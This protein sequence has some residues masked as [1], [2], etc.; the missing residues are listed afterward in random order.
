MNK[1]LLRVVGLVCASPLYIHPPSYSKEILHSPPISCTLLLLFQQHIHP[2]GSPPHPPPNL[3][4][5]S[6]PKTLL[7]PLNRIPTIP[8]P[9]KRPLTLLAPILL[10]PQP[11]PAQKLA[12]TG[13]RGFLLRGLERDELVEVFVD[14]GGFAVAAGGLVGGT[15]AGVVLAFCIVVGE[16]EMARKCIRTD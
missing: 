7:I 5:P 14:G 11:L 1:S 8:I 6:D 16:G 15:V 9:T 12:D 4:P 2:P 10:L 13:I 3:R